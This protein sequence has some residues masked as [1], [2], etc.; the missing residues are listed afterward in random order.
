MNREAE[1][2]LLS[3][4]EKWPHGDLLPLSRRG[5]NIIYCKKDAGIVMENNL[6]CVWTGYYLGQ[7]DPRNGAPGRYGTPE[8]VLAEWAID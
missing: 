6:C 8:E 5:G 2:E 1:L 3:H 7:V 4:P